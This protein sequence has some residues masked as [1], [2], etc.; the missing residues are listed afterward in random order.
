MYACMYVF[1]YIC[2]YVC[3][4]VRTLNTQELMSMR[5]RARLH[6]C[7]RAHACAP[8]RTSLIASTLMHAHP[9]AHT[10][11]HTHSLSLT[12]TQTHTQTHTHQTHVARMHARARPH[13]I[14]CPRQAHKCMHV[15][16]RVM[17]TRAHINA[18]SP[19]HARTNS[20][21]HAC[22]YTHTLTHTHTHTHTHTQVMGNPQAMAAAQK[23]MQNPKVCV[24]GCWCCMCVCV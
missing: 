5:T 8:A 22:T 13:T 18:H 19:K 20:H 6:V 12:H 4:R 2:I 15:Y 3:E 23:A 10:N 21:T 14:V 9:H 7:M 24:P 11:T 17:G 16:T 1:M